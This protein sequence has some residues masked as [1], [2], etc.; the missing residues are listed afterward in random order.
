MNFSE[1]GLHTYNKSLTIQ[2]IK[3]EKITIPNVCMLL[4][5]IDTS[6]KLQMLYIAI[7]DDIN[8]ILISY[9]PPQDGRSLCEFNLG[10]EELQTGFA[11]RCGAPKLSHYITTVPFTEKPSSI[12]KK[13]LGPHYFYGS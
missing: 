8:H 9:M 10:N 13:I 12:A 1:C 6:L 7:S 3:S 11:L 4:I 5:L 2:G